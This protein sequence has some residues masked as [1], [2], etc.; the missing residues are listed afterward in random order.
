[1][2]DHDAL[3]ALLQDRKRSTKGRASR[4]MTICL[5]EDLAMAHAVAE[6]ELAAANAAVKYA[7]DHAE[8]RAGGKVAVDPALLKEQKA[9]EKT[10]ADAKA[11]ADQ[12]SVVITFTALKSDAYDALQAEHPPREGNDADA[13]S[14]HNT[15]TFPDALMRASASKVTDTEGNLVDADLGEILDGL[16]NGERIIACQT[17]NLVNDRTASIHFSDAVSQNRRRSGSSSNR[18]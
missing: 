3:L 1:M 9:A 15:A 14:E 18:R 6:H 2:P 10:V 13:A 11:A 16:S 17:A 12:M 5:V 7:E 4:R 8:K